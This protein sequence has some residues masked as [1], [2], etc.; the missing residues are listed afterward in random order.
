MFKDPRRVF[1]IIIFLT[2]VV[3]FVDI[4]NQYHLKFQVGPL[5]VDRVFPGVSVLGKQFTTKF[6]LT[7]Q[8]EPS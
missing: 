8:A 3:A 5:K 1:A 4:P 6:D 7:F 2:L